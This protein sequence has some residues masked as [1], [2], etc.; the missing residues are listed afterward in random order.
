MVEQNEQNLTIKCKDCK[1]GDREHSWIRCKKQ[2]GV[3]VRSN[4]EFDRCPDYDPKEEGNED[5]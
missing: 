5:E 3:V 4:Q 2:K 1:N